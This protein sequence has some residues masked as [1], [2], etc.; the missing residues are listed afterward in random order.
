MLDFVIE[1]RQE[2]RF[3][4]YHNANERFMEAVCNYADLLRCP[5][6]DGMFI[7]EKPLFSGFIKCTQKY[8]SEHRIPYS[9]DNF[10]KDEY[11]MTVLQ[12]KSLHCYFHLKTVNDLVDVGLSYSTFK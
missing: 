2:A 6:N 12:G 11:L 4:E 7:N 5:L 3:E 8:A 9:F 1:Y 10:G